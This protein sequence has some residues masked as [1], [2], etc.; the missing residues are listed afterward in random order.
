MNNWKRTKSLRKKNDIDWFILATPND[1]DFNN[2]NK[3]TS[4]S[5]SG[6]DK[7]G[8]GEILSWGSAK[9]AEKIS[10][11]INAGA[12]M[13]RNGEKF[14]PRVTHTIGPD[15]H[16]VDYRFRITYL[17][18][19]NNDKYVVLAHDFDYNLDGVYPELK[20]YVEE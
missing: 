12:D 17:I 19:K 9:N 6:F 15:D 13:L 1:D 3:L 4:F 8:F 10:N 20:K 11:L 16:T 5:T 14:D 7:Y 18:D 2:P